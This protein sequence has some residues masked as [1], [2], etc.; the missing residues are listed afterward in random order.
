VSVAMYRVRV[1]SVASFLLACRVTAV[2]GSA[3]PLHASRTLAL[4]FVYEPWLDLSSGVSR[5]LPGDWSGVPR[6]H[7]RDMAH[8]APIARELAG[9]EVR[10]AQWARE[11]AGRFISCVGVVE[12]HHCD[13]RYWDAPDQQSQATYLI[14][15]TDPRWLEHLRPGMQWNT[16]TSNYDLAVAFDPSWRTPTVAELARGID[17]EHAF[18][19]MPILADALQDAG[20]DSDDLLD[21]LRD[22]TATHVRG[23]WALDLVL[24]KS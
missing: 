19:R 12:R 18:E 14:A 20:C 11:N 4:W 24:G 2:A 10:G 17:D 9:D 8:S 3:S 16:A 7:I 5:H 23:C 22:T 15:A 13:E 6:R 1:R 21:H